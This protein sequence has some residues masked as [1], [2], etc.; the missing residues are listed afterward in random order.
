[1]PTPQQMPS[2]ESQHQ[3]PHKK[4]PCSVHS[5]HP[6]I[7]YRPT[8]K[9]RWNKK[10][11]RNTELEALQTFVDAAGDALTRKVEHGIYLWQVPPHLGVYIVCRPRHI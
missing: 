1:M 3:T 2:L 6:C 9:I 10:E 11:K 4:I 5:R 7:K 8:L